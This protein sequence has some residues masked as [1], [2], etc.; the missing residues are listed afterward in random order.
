MI[1]TPA[2]L[3]AADGI[4]GAGGCGEGGQCKEDGGSVVGEVREKKSEAEA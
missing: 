3:H 1:E 2:R 4:D